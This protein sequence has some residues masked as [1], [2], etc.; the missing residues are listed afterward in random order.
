MIPGHHQQ[1]DANKTLLWYPQDDEISYHNNLITRHSDLNRLQWIDREIPY[2]FN[3]N[4]FRSDEFT[5]NSIVFL[6][7]S[8]T[9]G[10][11]LPVENVFPSIISKQLGYNC[12][13]LSVSGSSN[14]T[15]FR[16]A[17]Y[18]LEKI[19]PVMVILMSPDKSR[20][21]L[22][23]TR[24]IQYRVNSDSLRDR[25]YQRWLVNEENSRLNQ[26]K[27][28]LAIKSL[29][30]SL[31]IKFLNFSVEN[32]F[33]YVEQDL[34]RDLSHPGVASHLRTAEKIISSI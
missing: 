24:V 23:D 18:W 5:D 2:Q 30:N 28:Q 32:D 34:A 25:F 8:I 17:E 33:C 10:I 16:I 9:F 12:A 21:E 22:V 29:C 7:C 31:D 11:G 26:K 27:N 15:A 1:Q 13:N 14:D 6:G 19:N 20:M 3:S 4:G